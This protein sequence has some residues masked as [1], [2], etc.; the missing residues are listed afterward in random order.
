LPLKASLQVAREKNAPVRLYVPYGNA[1]VPYC[2]SQIRKRPRILWWIAQ[3]AIF[4]RSLRL[5]DVSRSAPE[6]V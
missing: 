3:D 1:W 4:G 6:K 2:L 5:L